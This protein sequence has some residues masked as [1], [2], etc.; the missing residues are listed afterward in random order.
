MQ[1]SELASINSLALESPTSRPLIELRS[2]SFIPLAGSLYHLSFRV[3][4]GALDRWDETLLTR[5][6][7]VTRLSLCGLDASHNNRTSINYI[8]EL[9]LDDISM[10]LLPILTSLPNLAFLDV[11]RIRSCETAMGPVVLPNLLTLKAYIANSWIDQLRCPN[12]K[13]LVVEILHSAP[14]YPDDVLQWISDHPSIKRLECHRIENYHL[15]AIA[16]PQL[17]HL[18]IRSHIDYFHSDQIRMPRFPALKTFGF[19][20]LAGRITVELFEQLVCSMCLPATHA[21][22]QLAM[23]ERRLERL[24]LLFRLKKKSVWRNINGRLYQEAKQTSRML[25]MEE[26]RRLGSR[27]IGDEWLE[28]SFAW[29]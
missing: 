9:S 1:T 7:P 28:M 17:E 24:D 22:S 3:D 29:M 20:D 12:I 19:H 8:Q 27:Y 21:R 6:P 18:V 5:F 10:Y 15:L 13:T 14:T 25:K 26:I 16:C 4:S 2:P 11:G 23:G